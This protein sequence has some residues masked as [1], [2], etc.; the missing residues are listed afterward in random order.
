[1]VVGDLGRWMKRNKVSGR[2]GN[3]SVSGGGKCEATK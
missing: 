3:A 2:T 1:M